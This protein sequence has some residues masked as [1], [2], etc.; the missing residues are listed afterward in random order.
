VAKRRKAGT[1]TAG[2]LDSLVHARHVDY[3]VVYPFVYGDSLLGRWR[4]VAS[5]TI[6]NNVVCGSPTV[7]FYAID[8]SKEE[9]LRKSLEAQAAVLPP[10]VTIKY[11]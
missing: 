1:R 10:G 6:R 4:K 5:W 3:A 8:P 7:Y 2:F 9:G 11:Y